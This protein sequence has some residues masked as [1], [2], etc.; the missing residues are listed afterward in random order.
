MEL[1]NKKDTVVG[2]PDFFKS[3]VF[4]I[5]TYEIHPTV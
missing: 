3:E 4:K 1:N 5:S 2:I